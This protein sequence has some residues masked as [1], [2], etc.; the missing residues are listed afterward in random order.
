MAFNLVQFNS[1]QSNFHPINTINSVKIY[2]VAVWHSIQQFSH[3]IY[4]VHPIFTQAIPFNSIQHYT[5]TN[6]RTGQNQNC[7]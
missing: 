2:T 3:P 6:Y 1:F 5:Y 4:S 7:N